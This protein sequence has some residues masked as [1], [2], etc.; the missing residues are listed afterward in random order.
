MRTVSI[1]WS[2]AAW[3]LFAAAVPA[4]AADP[5]L[6]LADAARQALDSNLDIAA[7]RRA[8]EANREEIGIARSALLPQITTGAQGEV[9]DDGAGSNDTRESFLMAARLDQVLYDE[10]DWASFTIQKQVYVQQVQ[11]FDAFRLDVVQDAAFAFLELDRAR[12]VLAIQQRN[13][14]VTVRN[15]ETSRAR[16]AAGWSSD[17]EVLRWESQLAGNDSDVRSVEVLVLQNRFALNRVRNVPPELATGTLPATIDEYGF[18]YS[19]EPVAEAIGAP[20]KDRR[21][22]D[23]LVRVGLA[24]SPDLAALDAAIVAAERQLTANRRAFWLPS[25]SVAAEVDHDVSSGRS[26]ASDLD[27]TEWGVQGLVEFPLVRGGPGKAGGFKVS[28]S[29]RLDGAAPRPLEPPYGGPT[30]S[31]VQLIL[32]AVLVLLPLDVAPDHLFIPTHRGHEVA[33]RPEV[34][35]H[36]VPA[37]LPEVPAMWIALFPLMYP[38]TCDTEYFGGIEIIMCT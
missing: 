8:L 1:R 35:P 25:F 2:I 38:I 34:L 15:L 9:I 23:S 19:R 29:K 33:S 4:A 11:E 3:Y 30:I 22:R 12:A 17:R 6:S 5:E 18:V 21:M 26:G 36:E 20:A 14:E 24:R 27:T 32:L 13:R 16:I 31:R 28:R 7:R 37:P 10:T